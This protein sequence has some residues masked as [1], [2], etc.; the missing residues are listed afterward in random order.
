MFSW[1]APDE[2]L[3]DGC[4]GLQ[5]PVATGSVLQ[6]NQPDGAEKAA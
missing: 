1:T 6:Y 4:I 5:K 2:A 3:K